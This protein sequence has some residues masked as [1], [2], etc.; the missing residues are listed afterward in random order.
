MEPIKEPYI[1]V[2]PAPSAWEHVVETARQEGYSAGI[3]MGTELAMKDIY[4]AERA[5]YREGQRDL[6]KK[7]L[8]T[9]G[10]ED[11]VC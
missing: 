4:T 10:V 9:L 7:L 2:D 1:E 11:G 6:I 3:K 5:A 8:G